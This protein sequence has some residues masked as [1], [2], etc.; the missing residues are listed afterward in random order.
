[1]PEYGTGFAD[2]RKTVVNRKAKR[3]GS[4]FITRI[5]ITR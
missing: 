5:K 2:Q 1:L 4:F 3:T